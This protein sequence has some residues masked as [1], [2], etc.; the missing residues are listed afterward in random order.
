MYKT[1][2]KSYGMGFI[3]FICK[4]RYWQNMIGRRGCM[5]PGKNKMQAGIKLELPAQKCYQAD[6]FYYIQYNNAGLQLI[7]QVKILHFS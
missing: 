3:S 7:L 5:E 6:F 2:L 4:D 1:L